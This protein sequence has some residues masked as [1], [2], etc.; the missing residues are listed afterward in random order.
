MADPRGHGGDGLRVASAFGVL[1]FVWGTTWA[2]IRVGLEGL[3]PLWGVSIRFG[4]AGLLLLA[5]VPVWRARIGTGRRESGLWIVNAVFAYGIPY[6]AVYRAEQSISSG[7]TAVLFA[8]YPLFV[9]L[10]AHAFLPGERLSPRSLA[11]IVT[12][13]AGVAVLFSDDVRGLF[14]PDARFAAA[15]AVLAPLSASISSVSVKRWGAGVSPFSLTAV[16]MILTAL[17]L[18]P[19]AVAF[20]GAGAIALDARSGAALVYLAVFGTALTF[21][22]W[23]WLLERRSASRLALVAYLTPVVAVFTGAAAFGEPVTPR[24]GAGAALVLAGVALAVGVRVGRRR[25]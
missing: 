24:M 18:L 13:F 15:L 5:L 6:V 22:L 1:T 16:P 11:G 19:A 14:G 9:A 7:L 3:P 23:F 12:G 2:A 21:V 10:L 20:E 17:A 25:A 8:T 4:L